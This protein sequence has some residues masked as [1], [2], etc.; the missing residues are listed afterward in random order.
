MALETANPAP[1][2]TASEPAWIG[3]LRR[4]VRGEVLSDRFS[5]G[6]YSTDASIYQIEPLGVVVPKSEADVARAVEIAR[7]EDIPLLPRGGGTSQCGQTVGE[8]LVIGPN[9]SVNILPVLFG[10][11]PIARQ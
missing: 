1:R 10:I 5:C 3:R 7:D 6:R 9:A 11:V 2:A 4:A 8:A